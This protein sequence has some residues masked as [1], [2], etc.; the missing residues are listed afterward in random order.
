MARVVG[1]GHQDFETVIT[2]NLFYVDKTNFIKEWWENE[3]C[4]TLITRPRRFGKTLNMSMLD[5]FFSVKHA[6]SDLFKGLS[7]WQAK[8]PDEDYK[9]RQLQGTYPVISLSFA[10]VK[11]KNFT[12]A[13]KILCQVITNLYNKHDFLLD[14]G[15]LNET[16]QNDYRK[17]NA[18]ME[19]YL[20][21]GSIRALSD[22]VKKSSSYWTNMI[23]PCRKL[24]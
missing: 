7:I 14:S 23:R 20:T 12:D 19:N 2:K 5:Y 16:E 10:D 15:C 11:A 13:R 3:D 8:S 1:I 18:E 6:G 4:V 22:Y 9:Y 21:V 17:I 24:M